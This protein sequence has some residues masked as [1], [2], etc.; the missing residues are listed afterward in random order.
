MRCLNATFYALFS[1]R[2]RGRVLKTIENKA[3]FT[4][5]LLNAERQAGKLWI[6]TFKVFWS[7]RSSNH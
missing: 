1:E 5:T 4:L 2:R 7:K 6:P 3:I